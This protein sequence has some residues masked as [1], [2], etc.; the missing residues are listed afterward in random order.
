MT[1]T[2]LRHGSGKLTGRKL[3]VA[4]KSVW[5]VPTSGILEFDSISSHLKQPLTPHSLDLSVVEDAM[6]FVMYG[7]EH[8]RTMVRRYGTPL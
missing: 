7:L 1:E 4:S 3:H 8:V 5:R 2:I 6:I